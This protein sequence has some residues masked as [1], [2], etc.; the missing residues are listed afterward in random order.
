MIDKIKY[1]AAYQV[2]PVSAITCYAEILKIEKYTIENKHETDTFNYVNQNK[3]ILYFKSKAKKIKQ[4]KLNNF[5]SLQ[6]PR[7]TNFKRLINAKEL[8]DVF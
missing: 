1:I 8:K 7:Y 5:T 3:Y 4:L 6:S 2:S